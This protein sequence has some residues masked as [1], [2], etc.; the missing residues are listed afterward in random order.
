MFSNSQGNRPGVA[1]CLRDLVAVFQLPMT[2]ATALLLFVVCV[3]PPLIM[4][5][6]SKGRHPR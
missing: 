2:L 5:V 4:L 6:L 1:H 3:V